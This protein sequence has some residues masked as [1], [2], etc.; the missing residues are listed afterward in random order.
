MEAKITEM[1]EIIEKSLEDVRVVDID[2]ASARLPGISLDC[3]KRACKE[4]RLTFA[5][6]LPPRG[7]EFQ[8]W[9]YL[10]DKRAFDE[11]KK[12]KRDLFK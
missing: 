4:D 6:G 9:R 2:Y 7:E 12:K 5:I 1:H 10:V 3:L 8:T 11:K